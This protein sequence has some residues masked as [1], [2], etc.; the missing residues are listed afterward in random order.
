MSH[1]Y[2]VLLD[3]P[4]EATKS[5]DEPIKSVFCLH[6]YP[7]TLE[8]LF[9]HHVRCC[10]R[11]ERTRKTFLAEKKGRALSVIT[12]F[13]MLQ[14]PLFTLSGSLASSSM[15]IILFLVLFLL[16]FLLMHSCNVKFIGAF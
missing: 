6:I 9:H 15:A 3:I 14:Q 13:G 11:E 2:I 1:Q 8:L 5:V 12:C 16:P 4:R 7:Y 10:C